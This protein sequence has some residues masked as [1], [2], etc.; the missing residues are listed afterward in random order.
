MIIII[1]AAGRQVGAGGVA[2]G[3]AADERQAPDP[4]GQPGLAGADRAQQGRK[5]SN[6][7]ILHKVQIILYKKINKVNI[8]R[9]YF[10]FLLC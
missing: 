4:T 1:I 7:M 9:L 3:R 5:S 6:Y 8:F 2:G 10:L